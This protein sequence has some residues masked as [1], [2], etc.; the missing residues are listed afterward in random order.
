[1]A[2]EKRVSSNRGPLGSYARWYTYDLISVSFRTPL[3]TQ[4]LFNKLVDESDPLAI[5][6]TGETFGMTSRAGWEFIGFAI[7][8]VTEVSP[9]RFE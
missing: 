8:L 9:E 3:I 6:E 4:M 1:M 7:C 2:S 5:R